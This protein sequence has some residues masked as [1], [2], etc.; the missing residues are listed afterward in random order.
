VKQTITYLI[1]TL[2]FVFPG[3]GQ[4]QRNSYTLDQLISES[5]ENNYDIRVSRTDLEISELNNTLGSAG[6]LPTLMWESSL[7]N[8]FNDRYDVDNQNGSLQNGVRLNWVLFKGFS[9][10]IRKA[11]LETMERLSGA[12][13]A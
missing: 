8:S 10:H 3:A 4:E 2:F 12:N 11:R 5:L 1:L 13:L 9:A 6:M 7:N